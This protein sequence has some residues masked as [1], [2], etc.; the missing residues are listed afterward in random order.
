MLLSLFDLM[1][2]EELIESHNVAAEQ[3]LAADRNQRALIDELECLI[4][5]SPGR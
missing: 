3:A 4:K 5:L 2:R 1:L